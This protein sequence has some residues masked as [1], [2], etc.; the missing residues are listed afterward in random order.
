MKALLLLLLPLGCFSQIPQ[1]Y[2]DSA[3]GLTGD[4]LKTQLYQIIKDHTEFPYTSS[5]TDVWDI[6]KDTDKDTLNANNVILLYSGWSV[7][8]DQ[9]YN[10]GNGWNREHVWAKS[11]GDFGTAIGP[12]TDVHALRPCDISVNSARSNRWFAECSTE[13]IDSDG[14]TGSYSSSSEWV[15]KPREEVKGDV[16][17]MIFYMA[18]RYEGENGEPDLQVIDYIPSNNNSTLPYHAR[19]YDLLQWHLDDPVSDWE[20]NRND[21]IYYGYQNNRNPFIDHPEFV[22]QIWTSSLSVEEISIEEANT[23]ELVKVVDLNG[24]ESEIVT[25]EVLLLIYSDG[26]VKKVMITE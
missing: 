7:D 6:L 11:H 16:A 5:A 26:S 20:V 10:N 17:R 15:W 14:A 23:P 18:T 21:I 9:E 8:A 4:S 22:T 2:Y 13:Y 24:K 19:L 25:N 1:G 12:G 3:V